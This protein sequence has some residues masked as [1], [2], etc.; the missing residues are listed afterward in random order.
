[1]VDQ[2]ITSGR[3]KWGERSRLVLLLPHGYEGNGPEH[4][5]ARI[6][7]FLQ[8]CA[9]DNIRVANPSTADNYFHLLRRQGRHSLHRPLVVFTPK[10]L[11]RSP[12]ASC[13]VDS[14]VNGRF[15]PVIDDPTAA[16]RRDK[17]TRLI[18]CSGK[19]YHD[20]DA[21]ELRTTQTDVAVARVE[22]IFPIPTD[23]IR[24]VI[25]QYP[26][27]TEITWVQEEPRNMGAWTFLRRTL[28]A[29]LPAGVGL[30]YVGRST[31]SSPAEGYPQMHK[32][33]QARI[34]ED[35][36]SADATRPILSR[37]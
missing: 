9:E 37:G 18:F 8:A 34:V 25:A 32:V 16:D 28:E 2:F 22:M 19:I 12:S 13:S 31:R 11:L 3:A 14:L 35:A 30:S 15:Q 36:F 10:S 27:L 6:E 21:S 4:S 5:S 17:V 33:E 7:R 20:L 1:M 26:N 23:E 24:D 29:E